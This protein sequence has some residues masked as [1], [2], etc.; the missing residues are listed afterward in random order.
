MKI[1]NKQDVIKWLKRLKDDHPVSAGVCKL[2]KQQGSVSVFTDGIIRNRY[3]AMIEF[4]E[5]ED[6]I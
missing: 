2:V 5:S 3:E 1:N 4:L 6:V